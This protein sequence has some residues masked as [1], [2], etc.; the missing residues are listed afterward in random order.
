[1]N[2]FE[3]RTAAILAC[4]KYYAYLSS[5]PKG[6]SGSKISVLSKTRRSERS[7]EFRCVLSDPLRFY[8]TAFVLVRGIEP[9]YEVEISWSDPVSRQVVL[10][11]PRN[12]D[13]FDALS[14][15]DIT[16]CSDMKYLVKRL[17]NY[18]RE[19][20]ELSFSPPMPQPLPP[21]DFPGLVTPSDEQSAAIDGVF[22][23]PVS[24]IWGPPGTG[25][26]LVVLPQCLLRYIQAKKRVYLLA[27]T[28]NAV[29]QMLRGILPILKTAGVDL[30]C[31]YRIGTSSSAFARQYPEVVGDR[32]LEQEQAYWQERQR[33]LLLE[34][35]QAESYHDLVAEVAQSISRLSSVLP[36]LKELQAHHAASAERLTF[37][38]QQ[39]AHL[40]AQLSAAEENL[41]S[42]AAALGSIEQQMT[43][44]ARQLRYCWKIIPFFS[45]RKSALTFRFSELEAEKS[46][47][48]QKAAVLRSTRAELQNEIAA[49][50]SSVAA[51]E[52]A[53]AADRKEESALLKMIAYTGDTEAATDTLG[54]LLLKHQERQRELRSTEVRPLDKIDAELSEAQ[55][56]MQNLEGHSKLRQRNSALVLASTVDS[57]LRDF[58]PKEGS[59]ISHVFLDEAGYT[60]VVRGMV[61]FFCNC[62]VT[63][64]GDHKQLSPV[65]ESN[66]IAP[67]E[68]EVSLFSV[69]VVYLDTVLSGMPSDIYDLYLGLEKSKKDISPTAEQFSFYSLRYSYR[70]S[71]RLASLLSELTY[72]EPFFGLPEAPFEIIVLDAPGNGSG[73]RTSSAEAAAIHRFLLDHTDEIGSYAILSPYVSQVKLLRKALRC[74]ELVTTVHR[75]QG[76]EYDTVILS[77]ADGFASPPWFTSSALPQGRR[78]LNTA[79]SRAKQRLIL[80]CDVSYWQTQETQLISQ[81]LSIADQV[82]RICPPPAAVPSF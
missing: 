52:A 36:R 51:L 55:E 75:A 70:F 76:Q 67:S 79:V 19:H 1:M 33:S 77:I 14:P 27:P 20:T 59:P 21:C 56:A 22:S 50:E 23:S 9:E 54:E 46:K 29:E 81:L 11:V 24:Y 53:V 42:T 17:G 44:C 37:D 78:V 13:T 16:I 57:A 32:A 40:Q 35:A 41:N 2:A 63:F 30:G 49:L 68:M 39:L 15:S 7:S 61:A 58:P 12:A 82:V 48:Q 10:T 69:P 60:S 18:Y 74:P 34:K 28:N 26:T 31:V 66:R 5:L 47:L 43:R 65:C 25:K 73:A 71:N 45:R 64:L 4:E 62:P 3:F 38:M 6:A 80:C 72:R 8:D